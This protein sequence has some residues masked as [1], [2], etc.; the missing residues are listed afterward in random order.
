MKNAAPHG[1]DVVGC[2][3]ASYPLSN[4]FG[5]IVLRP[6]RADRVEVRFR[7]RNGVGLSGQPSF[8]STITTDLLSLMLNPR[9][10]ATSRPAVSIRR[11]RRERL[12][13]GSPGR[14]ARALFAA[15]K[16]N[17]HGSVVIVVKDRNSDQLKH[18]LMCSCL[19][20]WL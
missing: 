1:S 8:A 15:D 19:R 14:Q 10:A 3:D 16:Y 4:D 20:H 18:A 2:L 6:K 12:R 13:S 7:N 17:V 5:F 9:M 11:G